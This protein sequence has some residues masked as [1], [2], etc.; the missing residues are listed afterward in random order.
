MKKTVFFLLV[1]LIIGGWMI[2]TNLNT[3]FDNTKQKI[4][5]AKTFFGWVF[6]VVSDTRD[7]VGYA[8]EKDWLP[9]VN[10]TNNTNSSV[11]D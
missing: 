5:F 3:D 9:E 4:T 1:F 6:G 8:A 2:Y 11:E 7:V 10:D